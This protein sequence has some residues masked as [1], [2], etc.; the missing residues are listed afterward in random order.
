LGE[1]ARVSFGRLEATG[2]QNFLDLD[3]V[4]VSDEGEQIHP[5]GIISLPV[6]NEK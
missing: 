4:P 5:Q 1:F 2:A 6:A 3:D